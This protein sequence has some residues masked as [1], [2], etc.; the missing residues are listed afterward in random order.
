MPTI[1]IN[2]VRSAV[3][4]LMSTMVDAGRFLM[5]ESFGSPK[6]N[7]LSQTEKFESF[8]SQIPEDS[9]L[10]NNFKSQF[11]VPV[12]ENNE[13]SIT[14]PIINSDDVI[15]DNFLKIKEDNQFKLKNTPRGIFL[16]SSEGGS[17][18]KNMFLPISEAYTVAVEI[19]MKNRNRDMTIPVKILL[20]LYSTMFYSLRGSD[21]G[22]SLDSLKSNIR[23]LNEYLDSMDEPET[24][25][26][27]DEGPLGMIK[28][29]LGNF[30]FDQ[31]GDMMNKVT[32]DEQTNKEFGEVFTKMT[33]AIK[34]GKPPLDAMG[35]I[36]KEAT[37]AAA[38]E[39]EKIE[40]IEKIENV[41]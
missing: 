22:S 28:N 3:N 5:R 36:I 15:Q 38:T 29:I 6:P 16:S 35:D 4:F 39:P 12:F 40:K 27:Q 1:D 26:Q 7:W 21:N 32:E 41:D 25:V 13:L 19:S 11:V 8:F 14:N 34:S 31:I 23:V 24:S 37:A 2:S 20:G 17:N 9:E 30:N 10:M 33:E 18:L